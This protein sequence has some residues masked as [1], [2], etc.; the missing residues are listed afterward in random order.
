MPLTEGQVQVGSLVMGEGTSYRLL[1]FNPWS[2]TVRADQGDKRAWNHGSWSGAEWQDEAVVPMLIRVLG[3]DAGSWLALH[4]QLAAAFAPSH[5]D[6]E[7]RWVTGGTEFLLR[8]R[9]RMVD[10][11]VRTLGRGQI[12]TK[13]GFVALN[14]TIYSGTLHSE[15]LTLPIVTGGL[16]VPLTAPFSIGATVVSGRTSVT[17]AGTATVGLT[18]RFDG[19]VVDPRVTVVANGVVTTLKVMVTLAAGQWLDVDTAARTVYLNG[20]ASRRGNASGGWPVLPPGTHDLAFDAS[21]YDASAQLTAS[22]RDAW[23]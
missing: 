13:T 6:I 16:T 18:T 3:I 11:R 9:P 8:G 20:T 14:P 5:E 17:N 12:V 23:H 4:Q 15:V 21:A 2:R 7:L 19:P 10:P 1:E 22:W